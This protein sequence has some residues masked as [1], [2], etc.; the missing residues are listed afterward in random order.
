VRSVAMQNARG[1]LVTNASAY[2]SAVALTFLNLSRIYADTNRPNEAEKAHTETYGNAEHDPAMARCA[3][4]ILTDRA[5]PFCAKPVHRDACSHS[6][7][8]ASNLI[9]ASNQEGNDEIRKKA[10]RETDRVSSEHRLVSMDG[11]NSTGGRSVPD[12]AVA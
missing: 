8:P 7:H 3:R 12:Y 5:I 10:N 4:R 2:D 1:I 6:S 9:F 11:V